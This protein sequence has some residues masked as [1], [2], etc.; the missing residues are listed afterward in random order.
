M[1][2]GK[3]TYIAALVVFLAQMAEMFGIEIV[4]TDEI[5]NSIMTLAGVAGVIYGRMKAK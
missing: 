4:G 1:L 3:K 2:E 5:V